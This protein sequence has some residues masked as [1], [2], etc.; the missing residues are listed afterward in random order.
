MARRAT[1]PR[2]APAPP[3]SGN[4][5]I[6]VW[7]AAFVAAQ[8]IR[9]TMGIAAR[10]DTGVNQLASYSLSISADGRW[11]AYGRSSR[12]SATTITLWVRDLVR[13]TSAQVATND[14]ASTNYGP[15]PVWS[16]DGRMLAYY[17]VSNGILNLRVWDRESSRELQKTAIPVGTA[18][19]LS[20]QAPQWT[21]DA[22][23]VLSIADTGSAKP[24]WEEQESDPSL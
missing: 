3:R 4:S 19:F 21:P 11:L 12:V 5:M 7:V 10:P 13:G 20:Y 9:D 24:L 16:P 2:A 6:A 22:R 1:P 14:Y 17:G 8:D 23:F 18:A 15:K